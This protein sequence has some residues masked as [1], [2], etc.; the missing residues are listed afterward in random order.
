MLVEIRIFKHLFSHVQ[1][2][3][4]STIL[5]QCLPAILWSV[6]GTNKFMICFWKCFWIMFKLSTQKYIKFRNTN[7]NKTNV[8]RTKTAFSYF[9]LHDSV[10][11]KFFWKYS[12]F[13]DFLIENDGLPPCLRVSKTWHLRDAEQGNEN[14]KKWIN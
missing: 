8:R 14:E 1:L 12:D 2:C 4:V 7:K 5:G 9:I 13:Q 3:I 6:T 10:S 11:K